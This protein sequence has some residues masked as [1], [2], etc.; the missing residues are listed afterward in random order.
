MVI[1]HVAILSI[2]HP[3]IYDRVAPTSF[4]FEVEVADSL[5]GEP[6]YNTNVDTI[7]REFIVDNTLEQ[8]TTEVKLQLILAMTKLLRDKYVVCASDGDTY[9]LEAMVT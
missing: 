8:T 3:S 4:D 9:L 1:I 5:A 7:I 2:Y 6:G